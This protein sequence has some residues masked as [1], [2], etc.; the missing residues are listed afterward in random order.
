MASPPSERA[1]AIDPNQRTI[2][3]R[4]ASTTKYPFLIYLE[5]QAI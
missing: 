3:F 5:Q 4:V 1:S 2:Q